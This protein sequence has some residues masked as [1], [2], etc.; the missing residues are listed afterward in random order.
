MPG[1]P[2]PSP[3]PTPTPPARPPGA[4]R[5]F[6]LRAHHRLRDPA[7]FKAVFDGKLRKS[8]GPLTVFALP[9]PGNDHRL[10]ISIGRKYGKAHDRNR[11]KRMVRESFRLLRRDIPRPEIEGEPGAY[12]LVVIARP[13][14]PARQAD[15][16]AWF[17]DAV[18]AIHRETLRRGRRADRR[19]A[20]PAGEGSDGV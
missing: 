2:A 11:L 8:R 17:A 6:T 4:P 10:G 5:T 3:N 15:Y 13:H 18:R 14:E 20:P 9:R 19:D 12:D 1:D 7:A 16:Q